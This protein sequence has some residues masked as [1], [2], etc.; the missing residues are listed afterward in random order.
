MRIW[1]ITEQALLSLVNFGLALILTRVIEKSDWAIFS[2]GLVF[3]LFAQG[4]QRAL[5]SLPFATMVTSEELVRN[6]RHFWKN[7][8]TKVTLGSM[9]FLGLLSAAWNQIIPE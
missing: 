5:I 2:L 4:F 8:N 9:L 6:T 3:V 7:R 1:A